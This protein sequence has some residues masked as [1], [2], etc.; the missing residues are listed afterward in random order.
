VRPVPR[1]LVAAVAVV[2]LVTVAGCGPY[3]SGPDLSRFADVSPAGP[4]VAGR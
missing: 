4:P 3:E 1:L 2:V